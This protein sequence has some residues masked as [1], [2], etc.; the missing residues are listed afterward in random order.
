MLF[1]RIYNTTII[2]IFS[3]LYIISCYK[4]LKLQNCLF[5]IYYLKYYYFSYPNKMFISKKYL[6]EL[7]LKYIFII[8]YLYLNIISKKNLFAK[9]YIT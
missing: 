4:I 2:M 8:A 6:Y 3:M 1:I 9:F 5:E 7:V